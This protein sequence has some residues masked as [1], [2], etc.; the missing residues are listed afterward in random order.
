[1]SE[2]EER[3]KL[4]KPLN[5]VQ[6]E[7]ASSKHSVK[8]KQIERKIRKKRKKINR[9][10]A[11]LR[12]ITLLIVVFLGYEFVKLPQWYLPQDAFTRQ[13]GKIIT[14]MNND[15]VS[16]SVIYDALKNLYVPKLPIFA[17]KVYPMKHELYK[18]PVIKKVY[19]RRYGFPARIQ[20]IIKERVPMVVIKTD[21][22]SKPVAFFTTDEVL[23]TNGKY[24]DRA[25]SEST[26]RI[27]TNSRK[28]GQDW[29]AEK[30]LNIEKIARS[31][32]T[33]SGEKVSYVDMRNPNDVYVKI[34]TTN[35]RLGTLDSTVFDRIKRI[36]TILP[37]IQN[38]DSR[39]KYIDLSWDKVNYLKLNKETKNTTENKNTKKS[40]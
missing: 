6:D 13:D 35:I 27:L 11:F 33:Y 19:V 32:E 4:H 22:N 10:K 25:E 24:M 37:Q 28:L 14:V 5:D 8:H 40:E 15:I 18:I 12:F 21:L 30:I 20:V 1:M 17:V 16:D 36:Y 26:L 38:V 39:I 34:Q 3:K 7:F 29:N 23:V 9:L 2:N 31:V